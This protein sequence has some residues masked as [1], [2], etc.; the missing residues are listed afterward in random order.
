MVTVSSTAQQIFFNLLQASKLNVR[1]LKDNVCAYMFATL[2]FKNRVQTMTTTSLF[3]LIYF[4]CC[5]QNYYIPRYINK[6]C[7]SAEQ[8]VNQRDTNTDLK[9]ELYL[10]DAVI[11]LGVCSMDFQ[12]RDRLDN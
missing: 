4:K 7:V 10:I 9:S 8:D 3:L 12:S 1:Y 6:W 5:I 11:Q 2:C